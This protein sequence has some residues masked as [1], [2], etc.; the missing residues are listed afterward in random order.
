MKTIWFLGVFSFAVALGLVLFLLASHKGSTSIMDYAVWMLFFWQSFLSI[1][2]GFMVNAAAFRRKDLGG[3]IGISLRILAIG[4]VFM[5]LGQLQ[6][7]FIQAYN[8]WLSAYV[9]SLLY[10]LP[11]IIGAI[12]III[13]LLVVAKDYRRQALLLLGFMILGIVV[14]RLAV[15]LIPLPP[16][17]YNHTNADYQAAMTIDIVVFFLAV[18]IFSLARLF[19]KTYGASKIGRIFTIESFA[20]VFLLLLTIFD[21]MLDLVP[22]FSP[23]YTT[24]G[25]ILTAGSFCM[26]SVFF[27]Y[28]G[29][30]VRR[31]TLA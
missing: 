26:V 14:S 2:G 10:L 11:Y 13:S 17:T 25:R 3:V 20:F 23:W 7:P 30:Y 28:L 6:V 16:N 21:L 29:S 8:L 31:L 4:L 12:F 27:F 18:L 1:S 22:G 19:R 24:Q 5:G 15:L 9:N